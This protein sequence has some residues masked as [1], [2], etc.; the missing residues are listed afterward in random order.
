ME[1]VLTIKSI[2]KINILVYFLAIFSILT[3]S[4]KIFFIISFLIIIHEI[5]HVLMAYLFGLEIEKIYIYPLGGISKFNMP[6]NIS[7]KKELLILINGPIFQIIAYLILV[8]IFKYDKDLIKVYHYNILLFNLLPI[9]PLDGGKILSLLVEK[10][11]P[12]RTS[13][14]ITTI[15]SYIILLIGIYVIKVRKINIIITFIFLFIIITKEK[16]KI[17]YYYNKFILERYLNNYKFTN[18]KIITNI[19]NMYRD[20][21]HLIKENSKYYEEKEYLLKKYKK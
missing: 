7:I 21:K 2:F 18:T 6:I 4:F 15:I 10:I 20:Y 1:K 12:Y 9:Y 16:C 17:E 14:K 8:Q 19:N 5:G 3:A 13:L 11:F